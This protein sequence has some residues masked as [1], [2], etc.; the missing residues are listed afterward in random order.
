M[1]NIE[2]SLA[3]YSNTITTIGVVIALLGLFVAVYALRPSR[4]TDPYIDML[5][6]RTDWAKAIGRLKADDHKTYSDRLT[7]LNTWA[8]GF[9]GKRLFGWQSFMPCLSL[10]MIYP[11]IAALIGWAIGGNPSVGGLTLSEANT[12]LVQRW[13]SLT[14]ITASFSVLYLVFKNIDKILDRV[15]EL[16][17]LWRN[18][19]D[20]RRGFFAKA[21]R[22]LLRQAPALIGAFAAT[23]AFAFAFAFAFSGAFALALTF[24]VVVAFVFFTFAVTR[25]I[26]RA[27][28]RVII[29]AV[30]LTLAV[31]GALVVV[32]AYFNQDF[33]L[34]FFY[35][36]LP[37]FNAGADV[38]S[39]GAT[40]LFIRKIGSGTQ[41]PLIIILELLIDL[42][43]ALLCLFALLM[44]LTYALDLW[45]NLSPSTLPF[46]W[47]AYR[48][49]VLDGDA[50]AWVFIAMMLASTLLPTFIHWA[51]GIYALLRHNSHHARAAL[52]RWELLNRMV[53]KDTVFQD[54]KPEIQ[55]TQVV[56]LMRSL[57]HAQRMGLIGAFLSVGVLI[58]VTLLG[59]EAM[60]NWRYPDLSVFPTP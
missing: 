11:I 34:L 58:I 40:R 51:M 14:C 45:A 6:T 29:G 12:P 37:L 42:T 33:T 3:P 9:Y 10:A 43:I 5:E 27:V 8:D 50:G 23:G 7:R 49:Q 39:V 13:T 20:A 47:R 15:T 56:P 16:F 46:D 36:L 18:G 4:K 25:V 21:A 17:A 44:S 60:I 55:D 19:L 22:V 30:A 28:T 26:F 32:V 41:K 31:T 35:G 1:K 54:I 52:E 59:I 57:K 24:P 48:D 53:P 38:I 2:R